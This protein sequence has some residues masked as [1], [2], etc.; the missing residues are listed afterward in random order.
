M[1]T[2][3]FRV[4]SSRETLTLKVSCGDEQ[5]KETLGHRVLESHQAFWSL[6]STEKLLKGFK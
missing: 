2:V 3:D 5:K 4:C 6:N 1:V